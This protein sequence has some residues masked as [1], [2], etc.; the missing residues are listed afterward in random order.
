VITIVLRRRLIFAP[1][2]LSDTLK[3]FAGL[4][5]TARFFDLVRE[6]LPEERERLLAMPLTDAAARFA[7]LFSARY[8]PVSYR[9][10]QAW[11]PVLPFSTIKEFTAHIPLA[12]H[13]LERY[14]Y[15][16]GRIPPGQL[17]AGAICV[18]PLDVSAQWP[19]ANDNGPRIALLDRFIKQASEAALRP[20]PADGWPLELVEFALAGSQWPGLLA[21]CRWLFSRTGNLWLDTPHHERAEWTREEVDALARDWPLY[22]GLDKQMQAFNSWVGHD[23]PGRAARVIKFIAEK[24][25]A[26][27]KPLW[28]TLAGGGK[29]ALVEI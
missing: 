12:W 13:S 18:C 24:I 8:F 28:E 2:R 1:V 6:Y 14:S 11:E 4:E 23:F 21:W 19:G 27:P 9:M 29:D 5:H 20:V 16:S 7:K 17:L 3:P 15:D 10:A 25:E 22:L 26:R